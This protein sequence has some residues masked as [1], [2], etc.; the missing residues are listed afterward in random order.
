MS[1]TELCRGEAGKE[2]EWHTKSV[3]LWPGKVGSLRA[4]IC[5]T[6]RLKIPG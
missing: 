1:F 3:T 2:E 6:K 5:R 4:S